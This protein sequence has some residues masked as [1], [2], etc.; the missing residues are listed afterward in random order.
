VEG[1]QITIPFT[2]SKYYDLSTNNSNLTK[3]VYSVKSGSD[4]TANTADIDAATEL[5]VINT[6]FTYTITS[7]DI[8]KRYIVFKLMAREN[9]IDEDIAI[10]STTVVID[11][12]TGIAINWAYT[13]DYE[14]SDNAIFN[15]YK[16]YAIITN[17][18]KNNTLNIT[19]DQ[20]AVNGTN[21]TIFY[22]PERSRY[23]VLMPNSITPDMDKFI[24]NGGSTPAIYYGK[25]DNTVDNMTSADFMKPINVW[26]KMDTNATSANMIISEVSGNGEQDTIDTAQMIQAILK[27]T[28]TDKKVGSL[29]IL[30]K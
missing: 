9:T 17:I 28:T 23:V 11:T 3:L 24:F 18:G 13:L 20:A 10:G 12:Y 21:A 27:G 7:S 26:L 30:I 22:S 1:N 6:S 15:G 16:V 8:N 25:Q 4:M 19:V 2:V 14:V 29:G 5:N